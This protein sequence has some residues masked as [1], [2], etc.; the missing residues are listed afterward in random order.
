MRHRTW[1]SGSSRGGEA[2]VVQCS[3]QVDLEADGGAVH[4]DHFLGGLI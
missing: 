2:L 3:T 4:Y 1:H